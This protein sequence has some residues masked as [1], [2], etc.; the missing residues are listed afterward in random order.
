M[1]GSPRGGRLHVRRRALP[2]HHQ[3]PSSVTVGVSSALDAPVVRD[4]EVHIGKV[5]KLTLSCDHR[6]L[7]GV[8][9]ATF[10]QALKALLEDPDTLLEGH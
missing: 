4:G 8:M 1:R 3:P 2:A 9:A 6:I 5:L 7:D 10:L